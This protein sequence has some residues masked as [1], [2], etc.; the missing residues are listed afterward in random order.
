[1]SKSGAVTNVRAD[2]LTEQQD[3]AA[4]TGATSG[5]P[6]ME[7]RRPP[8]PL[9]RAVWYTGNILLISRSVAGRVFGRLG[10]FDPQIL[11]RVFRC[12][13]SRF[14]HPPKAKVEAIL[15]WM[16]QGPARPAGRSG[17][18]FTRPRSNRYFQL[19]VAVAKFAVRRQMPSSTSLI[20]RDAGPA[21]VAPRFPAN[22]E[23]RGGRG[24]D[25]WA[26][27]CRRSGI[28]HDAARQP[29][30]ASD[31]R[32][33][34]RSAVFLRRD[35]RRS[36]VT[37][38][39]TYDRTVHVRLSRL[40]LMAPPLRSALNLISPRLGRF[41]TLSLLMERESLATMV[42][43]LIFVFFSVFFAWG[44]AGTEKGAWDPAGPH[45]P[46]GP[47]GTSSA[48]M[49]TDGLTP[50]DRIRGAIKQ[51][52]VQSGFLRDVTVKSA[53]A[54]ST[55]RYEIVFLVVPEVA[56][57]LNMV[58]LKILQAATVLAAPGITVQY[59]LP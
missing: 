51:N 15:R 17:S 33:T 9:F 30:A 57:G 59:L 49:D 28:S 38:D 31:A 41:H 13:R 1:M 25:R 45:P 34:E 58:Y 21:P 35:P 22:D 4:P 54:V 43:A 29:M 26:L 23:A 12:R 18:F 32:A 56:S 44:C 48:F 40:G 8:H 36:A 39:Y 14:S 37:T 47:A 19:H 10:V 55:K 6:R 3:S 11:E 52:D 24:L 2:V 42:V 27:D 5:P 20:A 46:A 16:S 53:M 50:D 7:L